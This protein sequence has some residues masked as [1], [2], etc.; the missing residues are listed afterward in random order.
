VAYLPLV[1]FTGYSVFHMISVLFPLIINSGGQFDYSQ[2]VKIIGGFATL[3][4]AQ[5]VIT[6]FTLPFATASLMNAYEDLFNTRP[7]PAA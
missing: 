2:F 7:A 3:S 4:L 6:L 1:L 5:Q